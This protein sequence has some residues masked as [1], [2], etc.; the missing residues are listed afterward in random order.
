MKLPILMLIFYAIILLSTNIFFDF[1]K[2]YKSNYLMTVKVV[3]VKINDQQS[4]KCYLQM[5]YY[6]LPVSV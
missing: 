3:L 1:T 6:Q 5:I 2:G 4:L